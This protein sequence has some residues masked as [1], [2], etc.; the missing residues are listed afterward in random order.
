MTNLIYINWEARTIITSDSELEELIENRVEELKSEITLDLW[1]DGDYFISEVFY[2]DE[3]EK[4]EVED[5]YE[6]RLR[7]EAISRIREELIPYKILE[8]VETDLEHYF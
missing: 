4:R 1:L 7:E 5:K 6:G 3:E 8:G 2:M